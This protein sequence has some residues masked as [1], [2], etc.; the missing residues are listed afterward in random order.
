MTSMLRGVRGGRPLGGRRAARTAVAVGTVTLA[1]A[2]LSACE[3]PTP[4]ATLS[5]GTGSV[6][7]QAA[8]YDKDEALDEEELGS[9]LGEK[10]RESV[11]VGESETLRFGVEPEIAE[12]GWQLYL[13]GQQVTDGFETTYRTFPSE[14]LFSFVEQQATQTGEASPDSVNVSIV[15]G[16]Q[17]GDR[18]SVEAHGVWNFEVKAE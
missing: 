16:E 2:A 17:A 11:E 4:V 5:V 13:N 10:D 8:C 15:E 14:Q 9:C 1:L 18:Q 6:S 7:S 3:K 12:G